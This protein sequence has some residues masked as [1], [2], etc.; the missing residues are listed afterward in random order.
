MIMKIKTA[1]STLPTAGSAIGEICAEMQL[2]G[3]NAPDFV[4]LHFSLGWKPIDV[5]M[6]A[7]AGFGTAALH[8]GS[9]CQGVMTDKGL[10][11]RDGFGMGAFAIWDAD[12]AY[13]TAMADLTEDPR[14]A[15]RA[16]TEAALREADREGEAPDLVWLTTAP[17]AEEQVLDGIKDVLGREVMIV[18]GSS[19]DNDVSG[20]W[21]Q[22]TAAGVW[23]NCVVVSVLFPSTPISCAY[24][25]GYAPTKTHGKVTRVEGRHLYEIDGKP[26]ASV[27]SAWTNSAVP[28]AGDA[29]TSILAASTFFP[30]GR[31][32]GMLA[33]VPFHLLAHPATAHPNG[34]IS[35]FADVEPGET[36]WL[37]NGSADSLVARAGR[38]VAS[39]RDALACAGVSGALVIY[40]GGCMLAVQDRMAEVAQGVAQE[41]G[42]APFLGV[43]SFGEQGAPLG[44]ETRHGNL[45]ISCSSFG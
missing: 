3:A 36:L 7:A 41:L 20:K 4:A 24:Q 42:G 8:G 39:S 25:S 9:S 1:M 15:A 19:A 29:D 23:G 44:I 2:D 45:M 5:Q 21:G 22:F 6:A 12:G 14:Q 31:Y 10:A 13:G 27:Y 38:V 32:S 18:G 16:A 37:M 26:A 28:E 34:A 40:C 11:M 33:E 35:L 43:F 30:L 17:G